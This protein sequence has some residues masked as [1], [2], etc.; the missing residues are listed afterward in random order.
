MRPMGR[1][2]GQPW[3]S[4]IPYA[5]VKTLVRVL[6]AACLILITYLTGCRPGEALNLR[7]GCLRRDMTTKL[8]EIHGR[9]WKNARD[10]NGVKV[11]EGQY[12]DEPWIAPDLVATA[13]TVQERLHDGGVL[14][15]AWLVV[16]GP[17][18]R[19]GEA[20]NLTSA[21]D[22]LNRFV[23]WV[24]DFCHRH[25]RTDVI[26]PDSKRKRLTLSGLR[27]TLAWFICRRPRGLVA[28]PFSTATCTS[29]SPRAMRA[30][31][32][33]DSPTISHSNGG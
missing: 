5:E 10:E 8:W 3:M 27:R 32:R 25:G 9:K 16:D 23:E 12:R 26:P 14:F 24:N 7:R 19:A 20:R 17:D 13:V 18:P 11:P 15:P 21:N 1:L 31:T 30:R 2:D 4:D 33:P 28:P 29:R 22:D 6:S